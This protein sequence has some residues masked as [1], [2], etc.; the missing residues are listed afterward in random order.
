MRTKFP[1]KRKTMGTKIKDKKPPKKVSP[2]K[3]IRQEGYEILVKNLTIHSMISLWINTEGLTGHTKRVQERCAYFLSA[4]AEGKLVPA[5]QRY[6]GKAKVNLPP[7]QLE[8]VSKRI[9]I[10]RVDRMVLDYIEYYLDPTL[11]TKYMTP[12]LIQAIYHEY[13]QSSPLIYYTQIA[14]PRSIFPDPIDSARDVDIKLGAHTFIK[15]YYWINGK[16]DN[17]QTRK[18]V[19][20]LAKTLIQIF[21][22]SDT[23]MAS[24]ITDPV[25]MMEEYAFWLNQSGAKAS[26]LGLGPTSGWWK[27]FRDEVLHLA[28]E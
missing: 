19:A 4:L 17:Y 18:Q 23:T 25:D 16:K 24:G 13:Y 5:L 20:A 3:K 2:K 15:D 8:I 22:S 26:P 21:R 7:E 28:D 12:S 14:I 10:T 1:G 9:G 11:L 27:S 6:Y